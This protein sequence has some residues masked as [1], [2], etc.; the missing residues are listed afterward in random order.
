MLAT[1][2]KSLS[3]QHRI[4]KEALIS[5]KYTWSVLKQTKPSKHARVDPQQVAVYAHTADCSFALL[6]IPAGISVGKAFIVPCGLALQI[7][8]QFSGVSL[9]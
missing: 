3:S 1:R 4:K 2:W 9:H 6:E 8:Y 5:V 7:S